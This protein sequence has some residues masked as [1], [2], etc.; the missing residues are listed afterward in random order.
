MPHRVPR[1]R[2]HGVRR[3]VEPV[4]ASRAGELVAYLLPSPARPDT[5]T[6]PAISTGHQGDAL[7]RCARGWC[8]E[9]G[10]VKGAKW[11]NGAGLVLFTSRNLWIFY[12]EKSVDFVL[13]YCASRCGSGGG[14]GGGRGL[15]TWVRFVMKTFP[16]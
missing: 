1:H 5:V 7:R 14:G 12:I 10:G 2:A 11:G 4:V 13:H 6:A 16:S 8:E 3:G 9:R 15:T